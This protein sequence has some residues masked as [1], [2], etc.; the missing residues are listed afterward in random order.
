M[1]KYITLA[2]QSPSMSPVFSKSFH[3]DLHATLGIQEPTFLWASL[4]SACVFV[5]VCASEYVCVCEHVCVYIPEYMWVCVCV[6]EGQSLKIGVFFNFFFFCFKM[7]PL[8]DLSGWLAS[9]LQESVSLALWSPDHAIMLS[10]LYGFWASTEVSCLHSTHFTKWA[11]SPA[12]IF[13]AL[14][15]KHLFTWFPCVKFVDDIM[16]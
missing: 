11:F 14:F 6:C 9:E 4:G 2:A 7:G 15:C 3:S 10:F 5:C 16:S 8:A 1:F 12:E 13:F